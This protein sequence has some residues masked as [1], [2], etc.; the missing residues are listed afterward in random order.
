MLVPEIIT[1]NSTNNIFLSVATY[2]IK[3]IPS[4]IAHCLCFDP[5]NAYRIIKQKC[6]LLYE[7]FITRVIETNLLMKC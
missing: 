1:K 5:F 4:R 6:N 7:K 2:F 3:Y